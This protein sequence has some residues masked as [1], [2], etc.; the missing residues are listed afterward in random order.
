ME[1]IDEK[2]RSTFINEW[3]KRRANVVSLD[4]IIG[5][6]EVN[7]HNVWTYFPTCVTTYV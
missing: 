6:F 7:A 1:I 3:K 4:G 5:M 2:R